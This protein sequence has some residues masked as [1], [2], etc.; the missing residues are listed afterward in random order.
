M[1]P[2]W[3]NIDRGNKRTR[4]R[5]CPNATLSTTNPTFLSFFIYLPTTESISPITGGMQNVIQNMHLHENKQT[6][7]ES[8]TSKYSTYKAV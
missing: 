8:Y 7:E 2:W 1:E 4:R 6:K 5:T 3:N